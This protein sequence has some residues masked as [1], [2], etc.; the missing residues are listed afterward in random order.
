MNRRIFVIALGPGV[1]ALLLLRPTE[2]TALE[3]SN[4]SSVIELNSGFGSGTTHCPFGGVAADS[5]NKPDATRASGFTV[6]AR[7][8]LVLTDVEFSALTAGPGNLI[9]FTLARETSGA[10]NWINSDISATTGVDGLADA[11][12][13]LR[14][15][16]VKSGVTLCVQCFDHS[17]HGQIANPADCS[18]TIHGFLANDS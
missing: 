16:I 13:S 15:A 4:A 11:R 6:P 2:T 1:V 3:P 9:S 5:L 17:T 14:G 10:I 12:M 7:K 8:V 18:A